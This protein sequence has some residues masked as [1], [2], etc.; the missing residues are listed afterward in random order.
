MAVRKTLA[1]PL[2][3]KLNQF[4]IA[5]KKQ[6]R[7][8]SNCVEVYRTESWRTFAKFC[9][10]GQKQYNSVDGALLARRVADAGIGSVK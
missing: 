5:G 10:Q 8:K 4:P 9:P 1:I 3:K 6:C 7:G 2:K